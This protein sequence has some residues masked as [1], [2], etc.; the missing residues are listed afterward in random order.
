VESLHARAAGQLARK[1]VVDSRIAELTKALKKSPGADEHALSQMSSSLGVGLPADYLAFLRSTNGAEGAIGEK[2]YVSVWPV[3]EVKLLNDEYAVKEFAPG[4][5]LFGSDGGDTAYAFDTR[6]K[7]ERIVEV[8]FIGMSL[9]AAA[10]CG[11]SLAD[12]FEY[13]ADTRPR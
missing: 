7:E 6:S 1:I 13:L 10:P 12:F 9:D 11:R 3:E 5:L 4:L 8:P 2:S